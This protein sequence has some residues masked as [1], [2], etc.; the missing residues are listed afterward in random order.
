MYWLEA[1][2][3]LKA[4]KHLLTVAHDAQA[5]GQKQLLAVAREARTNGPKPAL[6]AKANGTGKTSARPEASRSI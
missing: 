4:T 1:E 3:Q 2:Q 6:K 5:N